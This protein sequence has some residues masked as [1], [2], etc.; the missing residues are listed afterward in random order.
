MLGGRGAD[1]RRVVL[2]RGERELG[3]VRGRADLREDAVLALVG[4]GG[5]GPHDLA[6]LRLSHAFAR[7]LLRAHQALLRRVEEELGPGGG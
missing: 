1:P 3:T 4:K 2:L 7:D 6:Y 5:A